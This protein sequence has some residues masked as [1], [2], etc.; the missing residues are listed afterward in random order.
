MFKSLQIAIPPTAS[1]HFAVMV[2]A[3]CGT[4]MGNMGQLAHDRFDRFPKGGRCQPEP[5][6]KKLVSSGNA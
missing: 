4:V 6:L 5:S 2:P 3:Q 1:N